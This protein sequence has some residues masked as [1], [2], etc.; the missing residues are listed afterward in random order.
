MKQL[1]IGTLLLAVSIHAHCQNWVVNGRVVNNQSETPEAI[2]CCAWSIDNGQS[3]VVQPTLLRSP[4]VAI[5]ITPYGDVRIFTQ[6]PGTVPNKPAYLAHCP[7][8]VAIT[9]IGNVEEITDPKKR[10]SIPFMATVE[11][12]KVD[13]I[14]GRAVSITGC[15]GVAAPKT[16]ACYSTTSITDCKIEPNQMYFIT[17]ES[18]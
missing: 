12:P 6:P 14:N 8:D 5:S 4:N 1:T 2:T 16:N 7:D 17:F 13:S 11:K 15:P 3:V 9:L 18:L 10:Y